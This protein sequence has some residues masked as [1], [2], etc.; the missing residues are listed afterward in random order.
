MSLKTSF[1][2]FVFIKCHE[3]LQ[4]HEEMQ[5]HSKDNTDNHYFSKMIEIPAEVIKL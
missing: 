3:E 5:Y 4:Y 2:M 1:K